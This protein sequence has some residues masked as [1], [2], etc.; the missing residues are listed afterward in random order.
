MTEPNLVKMGTDEGEILAPD[1]LS[2]RPRHQ[3]QTMRA[4]GS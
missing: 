3:R 1:M 4:E 2:P